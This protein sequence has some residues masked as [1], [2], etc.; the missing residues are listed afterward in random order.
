MAIRLKNIFGKRRKSS[1]NVSKNEAS[2]NDHLGL[3]KEVARI[4]IEKKG[5][6]KLIPGKNYKRVLSWMGG[7]ENKNVISKVSFVQQNEQKMQVRKRF[8]LEAKLPKETLQ[9]ALHLY[10]LRKA[11]S[12]ASSTTGYCTRNVALEFIKFLEKEMRETVKH[13]QLH[14]GTFSKQQ[15]EWLK[16]LEQNLKGI[17]WSVNTLDVKG[18][19]KMAKAR[20]NDFMAL[21]MEIAEDSELV[22]NHSA[23]KISRIV[24]LG[25]IIAQTVLI[26]IDERL[27]KLIG[28]DY[29]D[30]IKAREKAELKR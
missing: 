19:V 15:G 14:P 25:P 20:K 26:S 21:R 3:P 6:R 12:I 4:P 30:E 7:K 10:R 24:D 1:A 23:K 13:A 22:L 27:K 5:W 2:S 8:L 17:K 16:I 11:A 28:Q 29:Y 9:T 18:R